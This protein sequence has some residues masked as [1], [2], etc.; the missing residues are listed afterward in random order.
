VAFASA[1][2][3][4]IRS[5]DAN[6]SFVTSTDDSMAATPQGRN[7]G[8]AQIATPEDGTVTIAAGDTSP[9]GRAREQR[10]EELL[11]S[12]PP[13]ASTASSNPVPAVPKPKTS[14]LDRVLKPIASALGINRSAPPQQNASRTPQNQPQSENAS[15][16]TSATSTAGDGE[17]DEDSDVTPPRLISAEWL[18][19]QVQ[20]GQQAT[21]SANVVDDIS[22]VKSV[23]GVI[24]GPSATAQQ[25]FACQRD[26]TGRFV[27]AITIPKDAAEGNWS[28]KYLTLTDNAGNTA[29]LNAQQ[30]SLM[31][32][33]LRVTSS[34]SDSKGP[35]LTGLRLD[36]ASIQAGDKGQVF[37]DAEDD[38]SGVNLVSGVFVSPSKQARIGFGCRQMGVSWQCPVTPPACAEC[39]PWVLEQVQLQ[40]K[41]NNITTV[42]GDN[43][44]V[45]QARLELVGKSCDN[46]LP[47]LVSLRLEPPVVSNAEGGVIRVTAVAT[48]DA[49]GVASLSGMAMPANPASRAPNYF[50]FRPVSEGSDTFVGEIV[51]QKHAP[52]GVWT[53]GWIQV[54]DKGHNL[55]AYAAADPVISSVIFRV[56]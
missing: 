38:K 23:S 14:L 7:G 26:E 46:T 21:F 22:G 31:M 15:T 33:P 5:F 29:N 9:A 28:I 50:S 43:P 55:K 41:A 49:C 39:G 48:D 20:D 56:E 16:D 19:G 44:L 24:G 11:R 4:R 40:D 12:A 53:I 8:G 13:S 35:T 32:G 25:G 17:R 2:W 36:S 6:S 52:S 34:Q 37:I 45:G 30:G 54:L 51:V 10:Y 1:A 27:A 3:L 47:V 42:R 18:P